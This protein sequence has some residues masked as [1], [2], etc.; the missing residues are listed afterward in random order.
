MNGLPATHKKETDF[1]GYGL[2]SI[3]QIARKYGGE[4]KFSH[5]DGWFQLSIL[6][7]MKQGKNAVCE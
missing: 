1:H 6:I 2:K 5:V 3:R 4:M 7:P